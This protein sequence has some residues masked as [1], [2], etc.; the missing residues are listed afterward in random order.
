MP[1]VI[2]VLPAD[3]GWRVRA[4]PFDADM[5]FLSGADAETAARDLGVRLAAEGT[6]AEIRVF[7]RDGSLAG[8][9]LCPA[10]GTELAR[11]G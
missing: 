3:E 4:E 6:P 8:R 2:S 5:L 10:T 9:F 1:H 11:A 7:L